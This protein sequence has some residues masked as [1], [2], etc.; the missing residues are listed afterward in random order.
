MDK[1]VDDP[2]RVLYRV[3]CEIPGG[4]WQPLIGASRDRPGREKVGRALGRVNGLRTKGSVKVSR[5]RLVEI[6]E[7]ILN[8]GTSL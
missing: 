7:R 3:D 1:P 5:V 4:G 6:T 8:E 2:I